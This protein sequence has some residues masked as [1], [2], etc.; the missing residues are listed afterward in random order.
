MGLHHSIIRD[1]YDIGGNSSSTTNKTL[2]EATNKVLGR[3]Y[4]L[5]RLDQEVIDFIQSTSGSKLE[6]KVK[7]AKKEG[8]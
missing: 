6:A 5:L 8:G 2:A 1:P 3:P 4:T 7:K